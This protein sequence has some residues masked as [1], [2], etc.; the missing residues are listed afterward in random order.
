MTN[1]G[2][3]GSPLSQKRYV[4]GAQIA[5]YRCLDVQFVIHDQSKNF[6]FKSKKISMKCFNSEMTLPPPGIFSENSSILEKPGYPKVD[7]G[8]LSSWRAGS[9]GVWL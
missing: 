6:S 7:D 8:G 2:P 3:V 9:I 1:G 5:F 4:H